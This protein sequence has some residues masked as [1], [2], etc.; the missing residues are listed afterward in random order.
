[1]LMGSDYRRL[2]AALFKITNMNTCKTCKYWGNGSR[3]NEYTANE[4][5]LI[6]LDM[7]NS[8]DQAFIDAGASD[9]SGLYANLMT[10]A[11]FGCLLHSPKQ[12]A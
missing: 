6:E 2:L 11:A 1:M 5:C 9:D 8:K 12:Q 3:V 4:C 7:P 10:V